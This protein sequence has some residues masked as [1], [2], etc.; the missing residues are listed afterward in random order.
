VCEIGSSEVIVMHNGGGWFALHMPMLGG[1]AMA[2]VGMDRG[3]K[4]VVPEGEGGE[5]LA[6][7]AG[8]LERE[9]WGEKGG[10]VS[11]RIEGA[12]FVFWRSVSIQHA[13]V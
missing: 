1:Q 12:S 4:T 10:N 13:S 9:R 11:E 5:E 8:H 3:G 2:G 7:Y 6:L